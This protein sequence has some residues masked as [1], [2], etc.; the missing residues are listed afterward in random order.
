MDRTN[1]ISEKLLGIMLVV[2]FED[3]LL[4][5]KSTLKALQ[6]DDVPVLLLEIVQTLLLIGKL[7]MYMKN[8]SGNAILIL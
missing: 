2:T 5:R 3:V 1:E 4:L 8:S 6:G 7:F